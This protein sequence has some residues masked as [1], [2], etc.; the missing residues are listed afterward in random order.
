MMRITVWVCPTPGCGN[1]YAASAEQR[2][3]REEWNTDAKGA[4]TFPRSQCPDCSRRGLVSNRQPVEF[5]PVTVGEVI[6]AGGVP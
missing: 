1:F 6:A 4:R 2:D 5:S 3:L